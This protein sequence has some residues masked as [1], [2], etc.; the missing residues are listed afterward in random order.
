MK[1]VEPITLPSCEFGID[2]GRP[3]KLLV[4]K[5]GKMLF[6]VPGHSGWNGRGSTKYYGTKWTLYQR[7][8][9]WHDI[10]TGRMNASTLALLEPRIA[11]FFGVNEFAGQI[12]AKHTILLD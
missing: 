11:Q 1:I 12:S 2:W 3:R 10:H 8:G 9:D 4:R 7:G 6:I 5:G